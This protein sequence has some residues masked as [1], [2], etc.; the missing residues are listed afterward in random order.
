MLRWLDYMYLRG[1]SAQTT[2]LASINAELKMSSHGV[3]RSRVTPLLAEQGLHGL[4]RTGCTSMALTSLSVSFYQVTGE[5]G[6]CRT[7]AMRR[8]SRRYNA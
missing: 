7:V 6:Y 3:V 4:G 2:R 1:L 8:S 5:F